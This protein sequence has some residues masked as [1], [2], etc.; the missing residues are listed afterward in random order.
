METRLR[1]VLVLGGLPRPRTQIEVYE[2]SGRFVGRVDM[3]YE[4]LKVAVEYDG[5]WHWKQRRNDDRRR[6]A[7]RALGWT[8]LVFSAEDVYQHKLDVVRAVR[9]ALAEAAGRPRN[10]HNEPIARV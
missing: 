5:A 6:D 4:A 3:G 9:N 7:L 1:L 2:P 8:V 10:P